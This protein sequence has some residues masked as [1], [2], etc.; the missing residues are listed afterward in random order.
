M[1]NTDYFARRDKSLKSEH[2]NAKIA[3]VDLEIWKFLRREIEGVSATDL[4]RECIRLRGFL[5]QQQ[6]L[7]AE[8][9]PAGKNLGVA[10]LLRLYAPQRAPR[11]SFQRDPSDDFFAY[12]MADDPC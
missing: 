12:G 4:L 2:L 7:G 10:T 9:K 8:V 1:K 5:L 6:M 3:G 11:A